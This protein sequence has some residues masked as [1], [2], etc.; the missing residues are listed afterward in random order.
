[1]SEN[2]R[3]AQRRSANTWHREVLIPFAFG[4]F[5][6][7]L[8]LGHLIYDVELHKPS[9]PQKSQHDACEVSSSSS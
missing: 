8:L 3:Q 4:R 2:L 5:F 7:K 6:S 9:M 1:M